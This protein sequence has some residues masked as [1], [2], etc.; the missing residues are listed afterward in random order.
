MA[1]REDGKETRNRLLEAACEVFAEKGY[2]AAKV[3][4]ICRR[5][6]ANV[7][8]V[9]Y[10]FG[11]KAALYTEAWQETFKKFAGPKP[12]DSTITSPEEQLQIYI[13]SLIQNFTEQSDQGQFTRL[14]LMELA[15]PTGLIHDIWHDLI[16]PRRQIVIGIIRKIMGTKAT[17]ETVLFCEMSIINQCRVL[18]TI[19]RNDLEYLLGQS[20]SHDLIKRLADHITRF[21]LAGIKA[22]GKRKI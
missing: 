20:L 1:Q 14:Y 2:H 12:P 11:D 18:L 4:D 16:E 13:H 10:Y 15:N 6:G 3:A 9:N 7:A 22:V 17:D 8:A 5:A 21:S 19:R